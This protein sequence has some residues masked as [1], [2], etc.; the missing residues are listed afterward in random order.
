MYGSK[1]QKMT[2]NT[3]HREN[4]PHHGGMGMHGSKPGRAIPTGQTRMNWTESAGGQAAGTDSPGKARKRHTLMN[5]GQG[6]GL[7]GKGSNSRKFT[8]PKPNKY[9]YY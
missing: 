8:M 4:M 5:R 7:A 2:T 3:R 1:K 6:T 9:G